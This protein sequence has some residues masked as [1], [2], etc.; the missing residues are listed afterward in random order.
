[1]DPVGQDGAPRNPILILTGPPG[2]GKSTAADILAGRNG[3]A[4]HLEADAFFRFIR[5]GYVEL[6]RSESHEQN[7]IVMRIVAAAASGYAGA[8]YSTIVDG[9]VIPGWFFE[10]LRDGLRD[11]GHEVAYAVLRAPRSVCAARVDGREGGSLADPDV[12][13]RL[14]LDF[15][16]LGDL[17]RHVLDVEDKSPEEVA[18]LLTRRLDDG[19]LIV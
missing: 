13:D 2:V 12:I 5:T 1:M 19:S 7:E 15:A 17:E 10:P 14:W 9:I 6:W 8:G 3:P 16:E 4:V 11:R 18:T